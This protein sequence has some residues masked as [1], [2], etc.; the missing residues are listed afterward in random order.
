MT[1]SDKEKWTIVGVVSILVLMLTTIG[2]PRSFT[3]VIPVSTQEASCLMVFDSPVS[4]RYDV[5]FTLKDGTQKVED[6]FSNISGGEAAHLLLTLAQMQQMQRNGYAPVVHNFEPNSASTDKVMYRTED[7]AG[8][9]YFIHVSQETATASK[10]GKHWLPIDTDFLIP[11][12]LED[13]RTEMT[14]G[15]WSGFG[16]SATHLQVGAWISA[17]QE[18]SLTILARD[19][20]SLTCVPMKD[21]LVS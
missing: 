12:T 9:S 7:A 2:I 19:A 3:P 17:T 13:V 4:A 18:I 15:L 14:K 21:T 20:A 5:Q 16:S 6:T 8:E 1:R 10:D 11:T